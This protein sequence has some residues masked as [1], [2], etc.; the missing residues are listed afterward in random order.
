M[1]TFSQAPQSQL[2]FSGQGCAGTQTNRVWDSSAKEGFAE[3]EAGSSGHRILR[4]WEGE[5]SGISCSGYLEEGGKEGGEPR[6]RPDSEPRK[7]SDEGGVVAP[8]SSA[9]GSAPQLWLVSTSKLGESG[10]RGPAS[11]PT[12]APA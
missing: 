5:R 9:R 4:I 1:K 3:E 7:P 8:A 11:P 6:R 12:T 10:G 2:I